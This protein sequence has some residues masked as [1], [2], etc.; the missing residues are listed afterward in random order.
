MS[1][2][3]SAVVKPSRFVLALTAAMCAGSIAIGVYAG[4]G[5]SGDVSLV[6]R[7]GIG[8]ACIGAAIFVFFHVMSTRKTLRLDI[9][10]IGQIRLTDD[11][12]PAGITATASTDAAHGELVSLMPGSTLWPMLLLLSLK[13]EDGRT[14]ALSILPDCV[15]PDAFR[16][17]S[18]A[19]R[20][21][22]A[23]NQDDRPTMP[24]GL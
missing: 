19:C 8:S 18:V 23:H 10:G 9:S 20:W 15:A 12:A 24:P 5:L 3:V 1:I 11:M 16:R 6:L 22:A 17:L 21:I 13:S 2:T 4:I 14:R 7:I